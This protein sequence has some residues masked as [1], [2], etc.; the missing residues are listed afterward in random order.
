ME[1]R[2]RELLL[3]RCR[4]QVYLDPPIKIRYLKEG[5]DVGAGTGK[6]LQTLLHDVLQAGGVE[7]R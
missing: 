6:L 3:E 7:L 5:V 2:V 1:N 4:L